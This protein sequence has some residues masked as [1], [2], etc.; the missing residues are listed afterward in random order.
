MTWVLAQLMPGDPTSTFPP[1]TPLDRIAQYR[2]MWHL[3]DPWYTQLWYFLEGVFLHGD[4]GVSAR[5]YPFQSV[6]KVI[7]QLIA[8][9]VEISIIPTILIPIIGIKTALISVKHT[10]KW[11]DTTIRGL[12][13]LLSA[14]PTFFLGLI[15]QLVFGYY[16]PELTN[17][18]MDLPVVGLKTPGIGNPELEFISTTGFRTLDC[19]LANEL[20]LFMDTAKHLILPVFCQTLIFYTGISRQARASMLEILEQDYIRTARAKGCSKKDV[21]NKH[22][23]RNALIPT[24]TMTISLAFSLVAGSVLI[25]T[26]FNIRGMGQVMVQ[27]VIH[28]DYWL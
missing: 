8:R 26:V 6:S 14:F 13:V 3:D 22:A 12:S 28:S 2:E 20:E 27:A 7:P 9:S 15:L 11:Q 16:L 24:M 10:N 25:E 18:M 1:N 17:G 19:L 23:L 21:Y 4:L 5:I